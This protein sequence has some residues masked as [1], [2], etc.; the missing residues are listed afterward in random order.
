M[1]NPVLLGLIGQANA[2]FRAADAAA[3]MSWHV[4]VH[5]FRIEANDG[6]VGRPT[7]EGLHR[8]GVDWVLVSLINRRNVAD[9]VTEI[10]GP[11]GAGLERFI[12]TEALDTA[13]LDDRRVRHGVTAISRIKPSQPAAVET[14]W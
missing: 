2:L 1:N 3:P 12:L 7:P 6:E 4:E 9:G 8:D 14:P 11:D 13:L 5:Q 10:A